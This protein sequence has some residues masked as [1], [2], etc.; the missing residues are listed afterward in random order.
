MTE[1]QTAAE[2]RGA[3]VFAE[4]FRKW[5]SATPG[6][7]GVLVSCGYSRSA[8]VDMEAGTCSEITLLFGSKKARLFPSMFDIQDF[9]YCRLVA[10]LK[11]ESL[12]PYSSTLSFIQARAEFRKL[13]DHYGSRSRLLQITVGNGKAGGQITESFFSD[14]ARILREKYLTALLIMV[15][16]GHEGNLPTTITP[17]AMEEELLTQTSGGATQVEVQKVP[18][19]ERSEVQ[20]LPKCGDPDRDRP[21]I[22]HLIS[23][24][25]NALK[26]ARRCGMAPERFLAGDQSILTDYLNQFKAL[27]GEPGQQGDP[28]TKK[29]LENF[30]KGNR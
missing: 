25:G 19:I 20:L 14:D 10:K 17:G 23:T 16:K 2:R 6:W 1:K 7:Q 26:L 30:V 11:A 9:I 12:C 27:V 29:D 4:K 21:V 28:L 13:E 15:Q 5:Q 24:F 18:P 8:I 22:D 3:E